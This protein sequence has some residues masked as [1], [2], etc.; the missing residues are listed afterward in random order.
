MKEI[1]EQLS[2]ADVAIHNALTNPDLTTR[3]ARYGYDQTRLAEG[4]SL[5]EQVDVLYRQQAHG[6]GQQFNATDELH[7]LWHQA[8]T[9]F[10]QDRRVARVAFRK[11]RGARQSLGLMA[12]RKKSLISWLQRAQQFYNN[13]LQDPYLPRLERF[14]LDW[15]HLNEGLTLVQAVVDAKRHRA[16]EKGSAQQYT[17]DRDAALKALREWMVDFMDI[18]AVALEDTPQY[19]EKLTEVEE[20]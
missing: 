8:D 18:A 15:Q 5:Y 14:G 3:L 12:A 7:R 4:Q 1:E 13:A 16:S 11:E 17:K 19:L 10:Y 20:S 2:K 9:R 6:Y